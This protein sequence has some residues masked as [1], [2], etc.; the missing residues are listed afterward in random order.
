MVS[1]CCKRVLEAVKP[2]YANKRKDFITSQKPGSR[3]FWQTANSV[4]DKGKSVIPLLFNDPVV[5]FSAS[6]KAILFA[7]NFSKNSH[8]LSVYLLSILELI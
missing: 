4:L 6:D 7:E 2:A 5:L 3:E 1:N 8:L